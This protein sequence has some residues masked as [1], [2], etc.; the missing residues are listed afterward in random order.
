MDGKIPEAARILVVDDDEAVAAV[1]SRMIARTG[2]AVEVFTDPAAA[3][4]RLARRDIDVVVSDISMPTMS[5]LDLLR[6]IRTADDDVPVLFLTGTPRVEDAML[7][8]EYGAFRYLTKPVDRDALAAAVGDALKW[9]KLTRVAA[10]GPAAGRRAALESSFGRALATIRMAYQP[11]V[12][13]RSRRAFGYEA[14]MRSSEPSLPSPLDVLDAAEKLGSLHALGRHVRD[15]VASQ[16]D[17]GPFDHVFFVNLHSADLA[18][19]AL[20][21]PSGAL[22]RH[23]R[24]VVLELTERA[25]LEG[26][27]DVEKRLQALREMGYR[28][29]VDDLGA[30][31]AGL[32]YFARVRPDVVKIDISLVR[33]IDTDSVKRRVVASICDLSRTLDM[34]VVAEG[35][36]TLAELQ[37][38][39][40]LGADLVQGY[41]I[42]KPG[43][44]YP[45]IQL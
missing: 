7:A 23:A 22:A 38:V 13:V 3:L 30:G 45:A 1:T 32:S 29:A 12:S 21:D 28:L 31:Y 43:P 16:A 44:P 2:Y 25:A 36:E 26:I 6:R 40:E 24:S 9:R 5:G 37:C 34:I 10:E 8:V 27:G 11:I 4:E 15:L 35:I 42:A 39:T 14:L 17:A 33:A 41:A 18:D 19:P 20:Y